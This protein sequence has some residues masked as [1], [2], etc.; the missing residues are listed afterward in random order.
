MQ[1]LELNRMK[2]LLVGTISNCGDKMNRDL[3]RVYSALQPFGSIE[4]FLVESDSVDQTKFKLN[5]LA[6]KDESFKY[7]SMGNLKSEIPERIERIRFCRNQYVKY[8]RK[9]ISK[10]NWDYVV[11]ADLDGMNSA[12]SPRGVRSSLELL[13]THNAVFSN[14][15]FGYYDLL[16]LRCPSWVTSNLIKEVYESLEYMPKSKTKFPLFAES[17]IFLAQ[18]KVRKEIIYKRM[19]VIPRS[20]L[21]ILVESA[22][23]GFGI[24]RS[25]IFKLFN[26]DSIKP[27]ELGECE[28]LA[29]HARCRE[30]GYSLAINP[31]MINNHIN[32]YNLNK[33]FIVRLLRNLKKVFSN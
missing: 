30:N 33:L 2:F 6:A 29:L 11:V 1:I 32:A 13:K 7:V 28:H 18:D 4:T 10:R 12:I 15:T 24:Y 19:R 21:P 8:I 23:G 31:A 9:N 5:E 16:A 22:F 14:Q 26:Y 27:N 3:L 17:E 25:E 20:G